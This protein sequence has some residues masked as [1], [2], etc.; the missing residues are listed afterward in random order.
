MLTTIAAIVTIN[1][2]ELSPIPNTF[3]NWLTLQTEAQARSS[4]GAVEEDHLKKNHHLLLVLLTILAVHHDH[5]L[6]VV[7]IIIP[8]LIPVI[9][10]LLIIILVIIPFLGLLTIMG[11]ER[12]SLEL[13][14]LAFQELLSLLLFLVC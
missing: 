3:S 4:G 5:D 2:I 11:E 13:S 12:Y 14:L 8:L 9:I 1:T 6:V 7:L 10:L